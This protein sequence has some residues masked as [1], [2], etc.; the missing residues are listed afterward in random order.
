QSGLPLR[1][2]PDELLA[3]FRIKCVFLRGLFDT[4]FSLTFKNKNFR[5][6]TYPVIKGSFA[7]KSLIEDLEELF[8]DLN[9]RHS[10]IYDLKEYD[11]RS[12]KYNIK[13]AIYLNGKDNFKK[14]VNYIGSSNKKFQRKISQWLENGI[15][16]PGY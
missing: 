3:V 6:Y 13:H 1:S 11:K 8:K 5:G 10:V 4:D 14:W 12:N 7:S 16:E 9:L 15:C 2:R